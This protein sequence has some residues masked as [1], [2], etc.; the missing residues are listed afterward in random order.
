V[1]SRRTGGFSLPPLE[2]PYKIIGLKQ[3]FAV[4]GKLRPNFKEPIWMARIAQ[5]PIDK[6]VALQNR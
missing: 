6:S 5:M 1:H 2:G 4:C 3:S